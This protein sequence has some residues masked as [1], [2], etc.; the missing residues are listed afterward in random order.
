MVLPGEQNP[1]LTDIPPDWVDLAMPLSV[2][3]LA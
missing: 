1:R 2:P 3:V